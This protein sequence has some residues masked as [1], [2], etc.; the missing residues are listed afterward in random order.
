MYQIGDI[1]YLK[2]STIQNVDVM[3]KRLNAKVEIIAL[4]AKLSQEGL[5]EKFA[6]KLM[7]ALNLVDEE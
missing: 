5:D 7:K 3:L 2:C 4:I 6:I 1:I